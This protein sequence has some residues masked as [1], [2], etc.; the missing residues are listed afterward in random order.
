MKTY[1]QQIKVEDTTVFY[2]KLNLE[3][4]NSSGE[5]RKEWALYIVTKRYELRELSNLLFSTRAV[6][7]RFLWLLSDVGELNSNTLLNELPFLLSIKDKINY[8]KTEA[9]FANYWLI[10]GV[11]IENEGLIIDLL[12]SWLQSPNSNI[13]TKSRALLVLFNLTNKYPDIKH[14]LKICLEEQLD[15]NSESFNKRVNK[16]LL[17]L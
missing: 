3:L 12:F 1:L 7:S 5:Q 10:A 6:A 8:D 11:P 15:K 2:N 16:I 14:E 17:H 4:P 13:T 9:S